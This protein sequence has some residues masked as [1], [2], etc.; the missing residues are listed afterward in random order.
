M[1][2]KTHGKT[3]LL[4]GSG[5]LLESLLTESCL[6][7]SRH[8][9]IIGRVISDDNSSGWS[10]S[11]PVV[12]SIDE[13]QMIVDKYN[14]ELFIVGK[15]QECTG[16]QRRGNDRTGKFNHFLVEAKLIHG[17]QIQT[18][19]SI[20]ESLTGKLPI[21]GYACEDILRSTV[22]QTRRI[23]E[24]IARML[25][26]SLASFAL[27]LLLPLIAVIAL[28]VRIDSPGPVLFVQKRL[29]L[30]SR[31]F[32]LLKFRT[33]RVTTK[34]H[35]EWACDND[36]RITKM[37]RWLRRFRLDE[38][39]QLLN[40][41]RGDMNLVGPRPHPASNYN[42][43]A[44]ASRNAPETGNEIPFY[45]L[46]CSVRPGITGWAQVKYCYANNLDEELEKLR[47]D[48]YYIKNRSFRMDIGILMET[49][50]IVIKGHD[51][52]QVHKSKT[53][54]VSVE[55]HLHKAASTIE[56]DA[57]SQVVS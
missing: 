47:Y 49:L 12:G 6:L 5:Q 51:G 8:Y 29:G 57:S 25:S 13:L 14:P 26:V 39:P 56:V 52:V 35:T 40:V 22:G 19:A 41:V 37:G 9:E 27:L 10:V 38:R 30:N 3:T 24:I 36:H 18:A 34:E 50:L 45:F 54:E 17:V 44:L 20:Y 4:I 7:D 11:I 55:T 28:I 2:R 33:M 15:S 48:L 21:E 1:F 42:L 31:S 23:E 43:F 32:E 53:P 46:R 16:R